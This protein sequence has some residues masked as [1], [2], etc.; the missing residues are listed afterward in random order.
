VYISAGD[1]PKSADSRRK[2]EKNIWEIGCKLSGAGKTDPF[3]S[4]QLQISGIKNCN[5]AMFQESSTHMEESRNIQHHHIVCRR[6]GC[7]AS[8]NVRNRFSIPLVIL[9]CLEISKQDT[10]LSCLR[11]GS[12]ITSMKSFTLLYNTLQLLLPI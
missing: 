1:P 6:R 11:F 10:H 9:N 12:S 3:Q 5:A 4:K 8:Q 2:R 7:F